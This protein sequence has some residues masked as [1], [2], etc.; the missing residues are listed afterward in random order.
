MPPEVL[1]VVRGVAELLA[2]LVAG[3]PHLVVVD[4]HVVVEAVLAGEG[5]RALGALVRTHPGVAAQVAKQGRVCREPG[6]KT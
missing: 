3:E 1:L 6:E 5:G 2:A 4:E